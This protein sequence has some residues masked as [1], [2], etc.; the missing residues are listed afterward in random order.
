MIFDETTYRLESKP[1]IGRIILII[2]LLGLIAGAAGYLVDAHR[3]FYSYLVAWTFWMSLALGGLFFTML[4]H[5]VAARWS[6]VLRRLSENVMATIPVMMLFFIPVL[7]GLGHLYHW[8]HP[9]YMAAEP[10]LA[11]KTAYLNVPFFIAR[12]AIYAAVWII[13]AWLLYRMSLAQDKNGADSPWF[14]RIRVISG[15]GLILFALTVTFAAVDWLMTLDAHWYSTIFGVYFF[16]GALLGFLVFL[17]LLI[18]ILKRLAVLTCSITVE[19]YHDLGKLAFAFVIFW[20]YMAFS[21]YF[22]IWYGNIPEETLWFLHRWDHSWKFVS[23]ALVLG[24]FLVPFLILFPHTAKRNPAV[25]TVM[26]L[27]IL[28][29][30]WIDIFWLV[31]PALTPDGFRLSWIDI[32]LTVGLGGVFVYSLWRLTTRHPLVPVGDPTLED[33]VDFGKH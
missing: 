15:L 21:Q 22:L 7:A 24:H 32:S 19:H 31:M 5:I 25:L 6:T 28:I 3:F 27:W 20:A 11:G 33:S 12:T 9:E 1:G 16:S 13:L 10:I 4:H 2:G 26:A 29:M 8:S 18:I 17:T 14:R 23:L 30:H